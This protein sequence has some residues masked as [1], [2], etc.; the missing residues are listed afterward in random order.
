MA[1]ERMRCLE[2][3]GEA[4][5]ALA[6]GE[7]LVDEQLP[8]PTDAPVLGLMAHIH[9]GLREDTDRAL[10]LLE[11]AR[12]ALSGAPLPPELV[13]IRAQAHFRAGSNYEAI[14]S[15]RSIADSPPPDD[16][17][18]LDRWLEMRSVWA[19]ALH[20]DGR[21]D[22]GI[23]LLEE[24]DVG[25]GHGRPAR[26]QL[27]ATLGR[28]LWH[29]GRVRDAGEVM[30][31]AADEERGLA[32]PDRARLLNN[33]GLARYSA[34]DRKGAQRMLEQ[35]AI[36][37][38]RMGDTADL[39]RARTNLCFLYRESGRWERAEQTGT[40][41]H[42]NARALEMHDFEAMAA[43]N[44]GDLALAVDDLQGA[45]GWFDR[46][47][48]L[49]RTHGLESEQVELARRLAELASVANDEDAGDR[50]QAA[51]ALAS[52]AG[53]DAEV[54]R[55]TALLA[56]A[57][58]RA[59]R[60]S[61]M[62]RCLAE[63]T[64]PLRE[65]GAAGSL[66]EVRVTA[67]RAL[68]IAGL[69][70]DALQEA[71]R[72]LVY[73]D[74]VEHALLRKRADAL[75]A[76]IRDIQ[77]PGG[78]DRQQDQLL[79]LAVAVARERDFQAI[80][81]AVATATL[82]LLDGERAFVLI[83]RDGT[84]EVVASAAREGTDP[85]APSRTVVSR[86][87]RDGREVIASDVDER[88]DL[89]AARSVATMQL[90]SAMCVPML[91]G[92][93]QVGALYVDSRAASHEEVTRAAQLLRALGSYAAVAIHNARYVQEVAA[94]AAQAAEIAHDLRSPAAAIQLAAMALLEAHPED[95]P[96]REHVVRI[97]DGSQRVQAM[98]GEFLE[99]RSSRR[100]RLDLSAHTRRLVGLLEIE[101]E[102]LGV[103]V[104]AE[105]APDLSVVG[106]HN[107]LARV[108]TNLVSNA[109][110]FSDEGQ[111]VELG[112]DA[113]E[114]HARVH[115]RDHGK[116]IPE[117]DLPTLFERRPAS[118]VKPG[119]YGL[120][121]SIASR[122]VEAQG[123]TLSAANHPDGGAEFTVLLPLAR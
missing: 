39:V 55:A 72:V 103:T 64:T 46:A 13:A 52:A 89:R 47:D 93:Q 6:F 106:D 73:A 123:G 24:L 1:V 43:G 8:K 56:L 20:Q 54:A 44:L 27:D 111:T 30:A 63:A 65:A 95:D 67:A 21:L 87:L 110:R 15:A 51:L 113:F 97:L 7:S 50:A 82:D 91:D 122:L 42:E 84:P 35:A 34:G 40:W 81:D 83:D 17:A 75:V 29:G 116:G 61:E 36:L 68:L 112:L 23:A 119:G 31:R 77:G 102:A 53:D 48:E 120:G 88:A 114:G 10:Q 121:L 76:S 86:A 18:K 57:H 104:R 98:A 92:D 70:V 107:A 41:A 60:T 38:E 99:E 45:A 22:E 5:E 74:E 79:A 26:A 118:E 11:Q 90:K 37:F 115:V 117:G 78:M 58:A 19:Q 3:A 12:E 32:V 66:A 101:A 109:V 71:T 105:I 9:A 100:R 59:G 62:H 14:D 49:A 2:A 69:T 16:P 25:L 28:L 96:R 4:A 33:A 108:V 80:L 94:R 85:G